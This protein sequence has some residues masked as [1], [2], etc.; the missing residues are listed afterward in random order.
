MWLVIAFVM[1]FAICGHAYYFG[2]RMAT[3]LA[4]VVPRSRPWLR[5]LRMAHLVIGCSLPV[6]ILLYAG[7]ALIA[8]PDR[9][10]APESALFDY[11]II[12]PF[13]I[14][15]IL[16]FQVTLL[17]APID[18]VHWLLRRFGALS[19]AKWHWRRHLAVLG[20]AAVFATVV[21]YQLM[22]GATRL[23][24]R[25]HVY[26]SEQ[27]PAAL[28]GFRIALVA[29]MQAD[30]YT[31]G[32]RLGELV[33]AVNRSKADLVVIAGDM[34]T[35]PPQYIETAAAH[36]GEMQAKYGVLAGVGDHDNFAYMDRERSL[37]EVKEALE[38]HGVP[39]LDNQIR[40]VEVKG[41]DLAVVALTNNY[42]SRIELEKARSLIESVKG[43]DLT[44]V[45]AHQTSPRLL[46]V[47]QR[48][49]AELFLSGHTHGGQ[50]RFWLPFYDLAP[51]RFE[52]RYV[53]GT[54][55]LGDMMLTVTPG[56]GMS[57]APLRYRSP[58]AI[59]IVRL[60]RATD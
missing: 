15:T 29:D 19:T 10:R 13:W 50:V 8:R 23:E 49:G 46:D 27:V 52:T 32:D 59:D 1:V 55:R 12:Y 24:V 5:R 39:L 38:R 26:R 20:V 22:V 53:D 34:I 43:R 3:A 16:S 31:R 54:Y 58:A 51:V 6:L 14:T 33:N 18:A 7:Y 25:E 41:A 2:R 47:A 56:L 9:F 48:A 21:P 28:D 42:V 36:A 30:R 60:E 44:V 57:V 40:I 4:T 37:R 17:I 35:R 11:L 45:L